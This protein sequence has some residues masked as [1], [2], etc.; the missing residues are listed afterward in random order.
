MCSKCDLNQSNKEDQDVSSFQN[1]LA[2]MIT[3]KTRKASHFQLFN[4]FPGMSNRKESDTD[5]PGASAPGEEGP[6]VVGG[7]NEKWQ[8]ML[9]AYA[10]SANAMASITPF[11]AGQMPFPQVCSSTQKEAFEHLPPSSLPF[12]SQ[13]IRLLL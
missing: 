10:K 11:M 12:S 13:F 4:K 3:Q 8:E 6:H 2:F 7:M 5:V 1:D 9:L